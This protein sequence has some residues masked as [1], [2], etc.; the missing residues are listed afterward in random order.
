[1]RAYGRKKP[2]RGEPND[3]SYDRWV[4]EQIKR[5]GA[6]EFDRIVRDADRKDES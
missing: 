3:R 2:K 6:E 1:M 4:E 5:L